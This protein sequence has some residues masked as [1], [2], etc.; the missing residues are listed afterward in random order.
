MT[1]TFKIGNELANTIFLISSQTVAYGD[2]GN[3]VFIDGLRQSDD[4]IFGEKGDDIL[5]TIDGNDNLWGGSGDDLFAVS[6][7]DGKVGI[8]GG[9][10]YD[11]VQLLDRYGIALN[12][13]QYG[14]K[15]VITSE[16]GFTL[17]LRNV[18]HVDWSN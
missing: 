14:D 1:I 16:D 12:V 9:G 6:V 4:L 18:E 5:Y 17:I 11:T 3:D 13:E 8:N 2:N 10:G 7:R 15:T